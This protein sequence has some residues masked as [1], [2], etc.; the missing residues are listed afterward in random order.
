MDHKEYQRMVEDKFGKDLK[1]IMYKLCVI[2]DVIASEGA[3]ILGVP[4]NTFIYWRNKFRFGPFQRKYDAAEEIQSKNMKTYKDEL[5]NKE[6][7]RELK[8]TDEK[9]LTGFKE[10]IERLL[11]IKKAQY[12]KDEE[13]LNAIFEI[14]VL[15]K[16]LINIQRYLSGELLDSL[17][18]QLEMLN[19]ENKK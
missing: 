17:Y 5:S 7:N 1:S 18:F 3:D 2:D 6:L 8:Y 14:A 9:S 15:E 16:T 4:K 11:E 13:D 10:I 19:S 12:L